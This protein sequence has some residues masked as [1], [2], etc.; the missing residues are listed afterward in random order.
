MHN[1]VSVME[2]LNSPN[3]ACA[4]SPPSLLLYAV[5]LG[6]MAAGWRLARR[7]ATSFR[8]TAW[9]WIKIGAALTAAS[10][11][12]IVG[13]FMLDPD[14][15]LGVEDNPVSNGLWILAINAFGIGLMILFGM[16]AFRIA[17]WAARLGQQG[18][19]T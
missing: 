19:P 18:D 11:V 12:V 13:F 15:V 9:R 14:P 8:A 16:A 2:C 10:F 6:L 4:V 1:F 17:G 3:A 5:I 7:D